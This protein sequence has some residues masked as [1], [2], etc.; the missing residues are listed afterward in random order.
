MK[1]I[2]NGK[3]YTVKEFIKLHKK[4]IF[5]LGVGVIVIG[6]CCRKAYNIGTLMPIKTSKMI[7]GK[8]MDPEHCAV[9]LLDK[10]ENVIDAFI[11]PVEDIASDLEREFELSIFTKDEISKMIDLIET[12]PISNGGN[13]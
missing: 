6:L 1:I 12:Y 8:G 13:K 3:T 11:L 9:Y 10:K 2:V 7:I 5:K 4:T